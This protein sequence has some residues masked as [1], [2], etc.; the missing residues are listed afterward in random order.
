MKKD[1]E[2]KS[3]VFVAGAAAAKPQA[4]G[5]GNAQNQRKGKKS[6]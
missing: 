3:L 1:A 5:R 2:A 6:N 4:K